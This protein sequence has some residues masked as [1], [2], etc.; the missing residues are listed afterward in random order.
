MNPLSEEN[1]KHFRILGIFRSYEVRKGKKDMKI[2]IIT[3]SR[4]GKTLA[5]SKKLEE[6]LSANG[7]QV[8]LTQIE[9][10]GP[11]KSSART[12]EFI[13]KPQIEMN[14]LLVFASPV[15]GGQ[16]SVPL[17]SFLNQTLSLRGKKVICLVTHFLFRSWGANQAIQQMKTLC[18]LK[19]AEI[20]GFGDVR[21]TFFYPGKQID[22]TVDR[23]CQLI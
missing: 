2:G 16:I 22:E 19:G 10:A 18:E 17:S 15:N 5:V 11:L 7:H 14:D 3:Y 9:T 12:V 21:W 8:T 23:V 6:K 20:I 4:S 13:S 1:R